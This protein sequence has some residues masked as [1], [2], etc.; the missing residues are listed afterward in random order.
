[1]DDDW[2][3][4]FRK[5]PYVYINVYIID[6]DCKCIFD[7]S[8]AVNMYKHVYIY[9][10][11]YMY[12]HIHIYI[13][14][15]ICTVCY[16]FTACCA[17]LTTKKIEFAKILLNN[18]SICKQNPMKSPFVQLKYTIKSPFGGFL[19]W[20]VPLNHPRIEG[21]SIINHPAIGGVPLFVE[22]PPFEQCSKS[23]SFHE[24]LVGLWGFPVLGL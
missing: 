1:M 2:G 7:T 23:L 4:H 14:I 19:R 8:K 10:Y 5:P 6:N 15:H 21:M 18:C 13:Y 3:Y 17:M 11:V 12:K 24:I 16:L 9:M 22:P 20:G